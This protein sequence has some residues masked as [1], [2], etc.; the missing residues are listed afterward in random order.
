M[1]H[2]LRLNTL[3]GHLGP[4]LKDAESHIQQIERGALVFTLVLE[5]LWIPTA[6]FVVMN[7]IDQLLPNGFDVLVGFLLLP[8]GCVL[9]PV[10]GKAVVWS[11]ALRI[12]KTSAFVS[13]FFWPSTAP[14]SL[15]VLARQ[16]HP[17]ARSFLSSCKGITSTISSGILGADSTV[18]EST[19]IYKQL[20][21]YGNYPETYDT[22]AASTTGEFT[23]LRD[24]SYLKIVSSRPSGAIPV[25][26]CGY[27]PNV[28]NRRQFF[29]A[30][31][32]QVEKDEETGGTIDLEHP[33]DH[34][35]FTPA[36]K[37][38]I[39]DLLDDDKLEIYITSEYEDRPH[40]GVFGP[41][42]Y[43]QQRH[44]HGASKHTLIIEEPLPELRQYVSACIENSIAHAM[45]LP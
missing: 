30:L 6:V 12:D 9:L 38:L 11:I 2:S 42:L 32:E 22:V 23:V 18:G 8:M 1:V 31:R 3:K 14:F 13:L 36:H 17:L 44:A 21:N 37:K 29:A 5:V 10:I 16:G 20:S 39:N 26:I 35:N 25:R 24:L 15:G 7:L 4:T 41:V 28:K 34:Y 33:I 45:R 40:W 43:I 27:F 19:K